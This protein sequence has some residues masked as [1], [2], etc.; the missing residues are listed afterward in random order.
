MRTPAGTECKYYYEDFHRRATQECRLIARNPNS[1]LWSPELCMDCPV[2]RI[3][4]A[5][6]CAQLLLKATVVRQLLIFRRVR[7]EAYCDHKQAP[8]AN[9]PV[10]CG[11]CA[12]LQRMKDEG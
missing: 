3:L 8:V 6:Q 1:L 7:V 2:P 4:A 11:E 10:G 12:R 5:N 9:P